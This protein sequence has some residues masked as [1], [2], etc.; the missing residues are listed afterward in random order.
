WQQREPD[1]MAVRWRNE[2]RGRIGGTANSRR[3]LAQRWL[4]INPYTWLA[5]SN[6]AP[7]AIAWGGIGVL[8]IGL[9]LCCAIWPVKWPSVLNFFF[10]ATLL[11]LASRWLI[12]YTASARLGS[13]RRDGIYELLLTTPL[14]PGEIV[15]GQLE[16]LRA[17][18]QVITRFVLGI[19]VSMMIAGLGLRQCD[20]A[21]LF[22]YFLI[23]TG[24][25]VWEWRQSWN[26]CSAL[27]CMCACLT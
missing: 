23:W 13:A 21:S 2:L 12:H 22:V 18:F 8:V 15:W 1:A 3:G 19:E 11:N 5:L 17:Q 24:L 25:L 4:A 27:M 6:R 20:G 14:Q 16:A 7:L 10:T 9:T 26:Q